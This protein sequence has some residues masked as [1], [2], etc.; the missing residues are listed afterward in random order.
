MGILLQCVGMNQP[1]IGQ[2]LS[3]QTQEIEKMTSNNNPKKVGRPQGQ[4]TSVIRVPTITVPY[5]RANM[6][7]IVKTVKRQEKKG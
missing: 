1:R 3:L 5:L 6:E 7:R 4:P 2:R